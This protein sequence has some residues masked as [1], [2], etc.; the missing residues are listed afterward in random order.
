MIQW[1]QDLSTFQQIMFILAVPATVILLVQFILVLFGIGG[2]GFDADVG[3]DVHDIG[4]ADHVNTEGFFMLGGIKLLTFR[5]MVSLLAVMGWISLGMYDVMPDHWYLAL[6]IGLASGFAVALLLA[7]AMNAVMKL[8][9]EGNADYKKAIGCK[10]TVYLRIPAKKQGKGK[11]NLNL[12]E[13][14][15]EI[16]AMTEDEEEIRTGSIVI[17]TAV[18]S[19]IAIVKK[20]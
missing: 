9:A 6:L 18:E 14:F 7:V 4:G 17:V 1:L 20:A 3:G 5:N 12:Q 16:D 19:E 8:Q 2:D 11:I 13:R 15:V 10:A